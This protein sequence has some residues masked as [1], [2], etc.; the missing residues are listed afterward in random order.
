MQEWS[1][2][3]NLDI[4]DHLHLAKH[5][6]S[7]DAL[8]RYRSGLGGSLLGCRLKIGSECLLP[9]W[10]LMQLAIKRL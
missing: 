9:L 4:K 5:P 10:G 7:D 2:L 1:R 8:K 6:H 3:L